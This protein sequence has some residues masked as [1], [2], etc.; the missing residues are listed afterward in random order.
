M[1][2]RIDMILLFMKVER[3]GHMAE[4]LSTH[5]E[6]LAKTRAAQHPATAI[7]VCSTAAGMTRDRFLEGIHVFRVHEQAELLAVIAQLPAFLKTHTRVRLIVLDS[8]AFHFRQTVQDAAKRGRILSG[9]SQALNQMAFECS[10]AVV[11]TNHVTTRFSGPNTSGAIESM[12]GSFPSSS[13]GTSSS[14]SSVIAPALGDLWAHCV[15]NRVLLFWG[16]KE[17][18][19][20]GTSQ[21]R[22]AE[23]VKSPCWPMGS[24]CFSIV[25]AGVRDLPSGRKARDGPNGTDDRRSRPRLT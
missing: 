25:A 2:I 23:I 8:I 18:A 4:A 24:A 17:T 16:T 13:A 1:F 22:M 6:K 9:L 20:S 11:I 14:V 7:E 10:L 15:T 21:V 19:E 5:L 3:V 12:E